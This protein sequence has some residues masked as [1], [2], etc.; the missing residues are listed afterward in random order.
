MVRFNR[1]HPNT[2]SAA[3]SALNASFYDVPRARRLTLGYNLPALRAYDR[4]TNHQSQGSQTHPSRRTIIFP[5][6]H[7]WRLTIT[8][9]VSLPLCDLS[10]LL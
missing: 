6:L 3:L 5:A 7:G 1:L 10:D 9:H 2:D 4:L 8:N